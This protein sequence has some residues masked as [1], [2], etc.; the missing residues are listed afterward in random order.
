MNT[1]D[2]VMTE[3]GAYG[4]VIE[5]IKDNSPEEFPDIDIYTSIENKTRTDRRTEYRVQLV[6]IDE[7]DNYGQNQKYSAG[8]VGLFFGHELASHG[9]CEND[10]Q[11]ALILCAASGVAYHSGNRYSVD[12]VPMGSAV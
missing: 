8:F 4:V 12:T 1:L 7:P 3:W 10:S 6:D 11:Q 2:I 9:F 5:V